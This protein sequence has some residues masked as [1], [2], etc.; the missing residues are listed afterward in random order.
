MLW[1]KQALRTGPVVF[2]C[3]AKRSGL[4]KPLD[5][6]HNFVAQDFGK[7]SHGQFVSD[8]HG[9]WTW[10]THFQGGSFTHTSASWF[11]V[12]SLSP[13]GISGFRASPG[14]LGFLHDGSGLQE[15]VFRVAGRSCKPSLT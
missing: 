4:A 8:S 1:H 12:A 9:C 5:F 15:P 7:G 13:R 14:S 2:C 6:I 3:V 10:G 11:S